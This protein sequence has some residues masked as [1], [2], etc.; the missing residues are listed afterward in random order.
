MTEIGG[1]RLR[2]ISFFS[3]RSKTM[4]PSAESGGKAEEEEAGW[5]IA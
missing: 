5:S 3:G 1:I 2:N 4:A